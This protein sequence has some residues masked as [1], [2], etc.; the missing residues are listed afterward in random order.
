LIAGKE[1]SWHTLV[2]AL[3]WMKMNSVRTVVLKMK[4]HQC[5]VRMGIPTGKKFLSGYNSD[6]AGIN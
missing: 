4:T 5:A 2:T 6:I 3:R 1:F